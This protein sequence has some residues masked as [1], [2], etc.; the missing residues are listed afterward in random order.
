MKYIKRIIYKKCSYFIHSILFTIL[1]YPAIIL[2]T[3]FEKLSENTDVILI[4]GN[5]DANLSKL[6]PD[7]VITCNVGGLV[8]DDTLL[9]HGHSLPNKVNTN[10]NKIIMGHIHPVFF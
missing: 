8:I 3:F 5:H 7:S 6:I 2:T 9:L 1:V 4:P 10:I